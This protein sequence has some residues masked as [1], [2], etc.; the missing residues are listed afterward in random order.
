[1]WDIQ[2]K[3][4]LTTISYIE[5]RTHCPII[6]FIEKTAH[7]DIE[8]STFKLFQIYLLFKLWIYLVDDL[9]IRENIFSQFFP[10]KLLHFVFFFRGKYYIII[11]CYLEYLILV[12]SFFSFP[13]EVWDQCCSLDRDT[14]LKSRLVI[15]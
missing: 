1:M 2:D 3:G 10:Q 9:I 14:L 6:S 12:F 5:A 8:S 13:C 15:N 7:S 11:Y 4:V